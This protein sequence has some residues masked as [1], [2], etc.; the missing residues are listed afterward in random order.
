MKFLLAKKK[1]IIIISAMIALISL[2]TGIT[3]LLVSSQ[4][5]LNR[6]EQFPTKLDTIIADSLQGKESP[7]YKVFLISLDSGFL[8]D[9]KGNYQDEFGVL[10][11]IIAA[12]TTNGTKP[13]W[14][15]DEHNAINKGQ[16][17]W[18][19]ILDTLKNKHLTYGAKNGWD[20][21]T[22]N[23]SHGMTVN[24]LLNSPTKQNQIIDAVLQG[25]L[26]EMNLPLAYTQVSKVNEI[27]QGFDYP[28]PPLTILV[29]TPEITGI[30]A[31]VA[32]T[33]MIAPI[34]IFLAILISL[35]YFIYDNKAFLNNNWN[36]LL[37]KIK[38]T[39]T[40]LIAKPQEE[41]DNNN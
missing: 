8:I 10:L 26:T 40:K 21:F 24:K 22:K 9:S 18:N 38:K 7:Y 33:I 39:E 17:V 2:G 41:T 19:N 6:L 12:Y 14:N 35:S 32:I 29:D 25:L 28:R 3:T 31:G 13:E 30:K 16:R 4:K 36:K 1:M 37:T 34:L 5:Q 27:A 11:G 23:L 20:Y 15:Q